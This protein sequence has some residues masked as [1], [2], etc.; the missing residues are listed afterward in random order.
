MRELRAVLAIAEL[1]SFRRAASELGYTQSALSHQVSALETS[2]GWP[3]FVR[4]GGRGH[5]ALT[6]AGEAVCRRARRILSELDAI[7]ADAAEAERGEQVRVRVGVYQTMAAEIMPL[8]LTTFRDEHP[9]IEVVLSDTSDSTSIAEALGRGRL[10][11]AFAHDPEPDDRV[12]A[13]PLFEDDWVVLTR[14]DDP[15]VD[16]ERPSFDVLDGTQV[17][18]WTRRWQVQVQL[19]EALARRGISPRIVY[20]TDDNLALQRLVAAGLGYACVGRFAARR[21]IDSSLTYVVPR[22]PLSPRQLALCYPRLREI[23]PTT[24]SLIAAIRSQVTA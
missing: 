7:P 15:L 6:P 14:R 5:V 22:D 13:V 16:L 8:A 1:G 19:E 20:R 10:D 2:L 17:V 3:L 18:A 24:L 23:S 11:L 9:G 12:E 4:P 21:A